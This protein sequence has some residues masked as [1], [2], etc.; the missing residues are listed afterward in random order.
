MLEKLM[1]PV[2]KCLDLA[3]RPR[4]WQMCFTLTEQTAGLTAIIY[5]KVEKELHFEHYKQ[6]KRAS[7]LE[8]I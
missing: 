3:C 4:V 5:Q 1:Y 2:D 8:K 7:E 6:S